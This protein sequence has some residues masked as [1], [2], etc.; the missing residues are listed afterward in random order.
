MKQLQQILLENI[1]K[2]KILNS[3]LS[4][5]LED[6]PL[7]QVLKQA[8]D[9]L[10]SISWLTLQSKGSISLAEGTDLKMLA[11]S[12]LPEVMIKGYAKVP[13]GKCIC[14]LTAEKKELQFFDHMHN[15]HDITYPGGIDHGHYGVPILLGSRLLGVINLYVNKGHIRDKSEEEFLVA[16]ANT[17]SVVIDRR[18]AQDKLRLYAD[19]VKNINKE[20][21]DLNFVVSHHLREPLRSI[22]AFS[23]FVF[24]EYKDVMNQE[25][26]SSL[27]KIKDCANRIS[28]YIQTMVDITDITQGKYKY[29]QVNIV[30]IVTEVVRQVRIKISGKNVELN[31]NFPDLGEIKGA[32]QLEIV[33][34][35][36][37][38]NALKFSDKERVVIELGYLNNNKDEHVFYV[39]DNGLGI[40]ERYFEHIF[41]LFTRL[42]LKEDFPGI[43]AGLAVCKKI[44]EI[45][46][47]RIWVESD[48]GKGVA[49]YFSIP[50][51]I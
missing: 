7:A 42:N 41:T 2:Q 44:I 25:S 29:R 45:N 13:F 33:F 39:K 21:S 6:I 32:A 20:L 8:L 30:D 35:Q 18:R 12:G 26:K 14:G 5:S 46:N 27:L 34:L 23:Q 24:N 37:V 4:L 36:L 51:V 15:H 22:S 1:E 40:E 19:Q 10:L 50:K 43:G 49:F 3:L 31:F 17:L 11:H 28:D 48:L 9:L 47:G 38:D 16:V